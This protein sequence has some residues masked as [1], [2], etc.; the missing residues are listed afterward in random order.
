MCLRMLLL[1]L[2]AVSALPSSSWAQAGV[3]IATIVEGEVTLIRDSSRL[4]VA[5]GVRV[6]ADDLLESAP[7][8]KLARIEFG[9]GMLLDIGPGTRVLVAPR[10]PGERGGTRSAR[11]YLLKGWAKLTAAKD[12]GVES[13]SVA[14]ESFDVTGIGRDVV[15]D[16]E[17]T[18]TAA[19]AESGDVL[20]LERGKGKA[21]ASFRLRVGDFIARVGD[22]KSVI[23]PRPSADFIQRVPRAFLDTLPSRS[24]QFAAREVQPKRL[25]D[26]AYTDAQPWLDAETALRP[27]FV[28]RWKALAQ[29]PEFRKGLVAGLRSHPEWDRVLYPEKY[30]PKPS[31]S[32]ASAVAGAYR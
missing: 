30:L 25:A 12:K 5:E 2:V 3:G 22:A 13:A 24:A 17:P 32:A 7:E 31:A 27:L 19:F 15:L 28:T 16:V 4:A 20:V 11:L 8:A 18:G 23:T 6:R 21:G 29:A 14:T 26:I 9:D 1:L 10:F